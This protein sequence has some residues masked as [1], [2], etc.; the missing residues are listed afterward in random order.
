MA[1]AEAPESVQIETLTIALAEQRRVYDWI[2]NNYEQ[3]RVKILSLLGGGLAA[4]TFL[5]ANG[6]LFIP[7]QVYG[8]ILYFA[9]LGMIIISLSCLVLALR[10]LPWEFPIADKDLLKIH[11]VPSKYEYLQ[12]M[13]ERHMEC[14]TINIGAYN[15]K[16]RLFNISLYPLIFGVIILVVM[17][18]FK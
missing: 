7:A 1:I 15:Y 11:K 8:K 12:Y 5:Y 17:K 10:P 18:L 2:S 9:A 6:E 16:Q 13:K 3:V 4:L 14:Y